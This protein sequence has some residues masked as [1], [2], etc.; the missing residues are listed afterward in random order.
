MHPNTRSRKDGRFTLYVGWYA[1]QKKM[2]IAAPGYE[3]LTTNLGPR[4]LGQRKVSRTYLL[5]RVGNPTSGQS[6]GAAGVHAVGGGEGRSAGRRD[7]NDQG[8]GAVGARLEGV[9]NR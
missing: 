6:E 4:A 3:T 7:A 8:R 2:T 1:E 9:P 5:R